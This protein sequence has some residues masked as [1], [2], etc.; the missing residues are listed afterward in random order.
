MTR[1]IVVKLPFG[2]LNIHAIPC[3]EEG[4][5]ISETCKDS[6]VYHINIYKGV[7]LSPALWASSPQGA[8]RKSHLFAMEERYGF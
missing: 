7:G 8:R 3:A 2:N 4:K 1:K 5:E 6:I